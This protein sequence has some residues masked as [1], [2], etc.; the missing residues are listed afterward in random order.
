MSAV[1]WLSSPNPIVLYGPLSAASLW[2]WPVF[3]GSYHDHRPRFIRM[4]WLCCLLSLAVPPGC[5]RRQ[6]EALSTFTMALP[7]TGVL[8]SP[9]NTSQTLWV[10][11][12]LPFLWV[13]GEV[14]FR[15]Y[16]KVVFSV[17][18]PLNELPIESTARRE[19]RETHCPFIAHHV[20]AI[21][22][23]NR[24]SLPYQHPFDRLE[25]EA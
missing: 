15:M 22:E 24:V 8:L 25:I 23:G 4:P 16:H 7:R 3:P 13:L 9:R 14:G 10:Y 5:R 12:A 17:A 2:L 1:L 19:P 11:I 20:T 21:E 6:K 18:F